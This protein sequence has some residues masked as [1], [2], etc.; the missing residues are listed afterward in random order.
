[1]QKVGEPKQLDGLTAGEHL[2]KLPILRGWNG[3]HDADDWMTVGTGR[4][5]QAIRS[6]KEEMEG[7]ADIKEEWK[8]WA[9]LL[10]Y[11]LVEYAKTAEFAGF[12][13]PSCEKCI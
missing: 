7:S 5:L 9:T 1:M 8:K 11:E 6:Q 10:T 13:C 2:M 3:N 12:E 4:K